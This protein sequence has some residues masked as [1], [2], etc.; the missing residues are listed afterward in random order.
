MGSSSHQQWLPVATRQGPVQRASKPRHRV[1]QYARQQTSHKHHGHHARSVPLIGGHGEII[2]GEHPQDRSRGRSKD[3]VLSIIEIEEIK[4][5]QTLDE[6]NDEKK[7]KQREALRDVFVVKLEEV[8]ED[9][10]EL[11]R[12]PDG[13]GS[14][15]EDKIEVVARWI[16]PQTVIGDQETEEGHDSNGEG[17]DGPFEMPAELRDAHRDTGDGIPI[18]QS[19]RDDVSGPIRQPL[20]DGESKEEDIEQYGDDEREFRVAD[21]V[22]LC[23]SA[24]ADSDGEEKDV[25]ARVDK[26][27]R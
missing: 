14:V 15:D 8:V 6:N 12:G 11:E 19:F 4:R 2:H 18:S 17:R 10:V 13:E 25:R 20:E 22:V 26:F 3:P 5:R 9:S 21:T 27:S 7:I 24:N 16:I 23:E 1:S